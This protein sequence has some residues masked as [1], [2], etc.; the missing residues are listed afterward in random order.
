MKNLQ[1]IWKVCKLCLLT[2][3]ETWEVIMK[4]VRTFLIRPK[5]LHSMVFD[6]LDQFSS[7][8]FDISLF[9]VYITLDTILGK[10]LLIILKFRY[11]I[12]FSY[13][14]KILSILVIGIKRC[15][16]V[17]A[18]YISYI[19]NPNSRRHIVCVLQSI[20]TGKGSNQILVYRHWSHF[21]VLPFSVVLNW[22]RKQ[23]HK[24]FHP[25]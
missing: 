18:V 9:K 6:L 19:I 7:Y 4:A 11:V 8:M 5:L 16:T 23:T 13:L 12:N 10:I 17:C 25:Y 2:L 24:T 21:L 22:F 20:Y 14:N 15:I 1:F 3:P